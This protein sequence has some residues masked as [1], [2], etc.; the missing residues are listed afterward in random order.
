MDDFESYTDDMDAGQAIFQTWIDGWVKGVAIVPVLN[1]SV[2]LIRQYRIAIDREIVELPAGR[3]EDEEEPESC[4]RRELEE[5]IGYSAGQMVLM[6]HTIPPWVS[7]MKKC[8]YFWHSNFGGQRR[9]LNRT[10]EF[11]R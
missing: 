2:I 5:E 3:L 1:D 4:A 9:N 8:I 7:R 10:R 6:D 11:R